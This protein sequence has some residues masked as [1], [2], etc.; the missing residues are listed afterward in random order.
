MTV[1]AAQRL[2]EI[3]VRG[4]REDLKAFLDEML[5]EL[6]RRGFSPS[7][8]EKERDAIRGFAVQ[9][10]E[11]PAIKIELQRGPQHFRLKQVPADFR[12]S[13]DRS[14]LHLCAWLA[15]MCERDD[16]N[17]VDPWTPYLTELAASAFDYPSVERTVAS[18]LDPLVKTGAKVRAPFERQNDL[19]AKEAAAKVVEWQRLADEKWAQPQHAGKSKS[20]IAEL[21]DREHADLIRRRIKKK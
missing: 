9:S 11:D 16:R 10:E 1:S 15:D 5:I 18:E 17:L 3:L 12:G 4:K 2:L 13:P 14:L 19:R 20:A 7:T 6:M 21:I 8:F